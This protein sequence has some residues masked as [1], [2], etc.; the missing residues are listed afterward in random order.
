M[1]RRWGFYQTDERKLPGLIADFIFMQFRFN[2][3]LK[4]CSQII[5]EA[6]SGQ[7]RLSDIAFDD[8][9]LLTD[10]ECDESDEDS[11]AQDVREDDDGVLT[12]ESCVNRCFEDKNSTVRLNANHTLSCSCSVDCDPKASCCP[13]FIG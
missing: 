1:A 3:K 6:V 13:D 9:S 2:M 11:K 10:D 8:V 7:T 5:I 12:V 4:F